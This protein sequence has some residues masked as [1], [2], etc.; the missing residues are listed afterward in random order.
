MALLD[1][2]LGGVLGSNNDSREESVS[3]SENS[4]EIGTNPQFGL[5]LSDVLQSESKSTDGEDGDSDHQSFTGIGDLGLGLAAPTFL[6]TSSS[7][8]S[9]SSSETDSNGG[10]GGLLGGLL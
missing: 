6:G 2:L 7:N 3:S 9:A 4:T 1:D 5:S 8:D 10:G